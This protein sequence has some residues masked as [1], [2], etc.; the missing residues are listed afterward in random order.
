[1]NRTYRLATLPMLFLLAHCT[2]YASDSVQDAPLL[3]PTP[4]RDLGE[5]IQAP[6]PYA[7]R[8]AGECLRVKGSVLGGTTTVTDGT[9]DALDAAENCVESGHP[10]GTKGLVLTDR[11]NPLLYARQT[12]TRTTLPSGGKVGLEYFRDDSGYRV[13][14]GDL[15][16]RLSGGQGSL[17]PMELSTTQSSIAGTLFPWTAAAGTWA[18]PGDLVTTSPGMRLGRTPLDAQMFAQGAGGAWDFSAFPAQVALDPGVLLVPIQAVLFYGAGQEAYAGTFAQDQLALWDRIPTSVGP[19]G[20]R[21]QLGSPG[22]IDAT[23]QP[24]LRVKTRPGKDTGF[25]SQYLPDDVWAACGIQ[26]R[27]VNVIPMRVDA[28]FLSPSGHLDAQSAVI[29][30]HD[31]IREDPRFQPGP[32]TVLFAPRCADVDAGSGGGFEGIAGQSRNERKFSCVSN[33][34]GGN[35]LAH[36]LGH[37]IMNDT[38]HSTLPGN[39]MNAASGAGT[40]LD[41]YRQCAAARAHVE[42]LKIAMP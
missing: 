7:S 22:S 38:G 6:R 2:E 8:P 17:D 25:Y 31:H 16:F 1:M 18:A 39:V 4:P 30:A 32:I 40:S 3:A 15:Q 42:A 27:L 33:K 41:V 36:E 10:S 20:G 11:D 34:G 24:L 12:L 23:L 19:N 13:G 5:R 37:V 14:H 35:T 28:T 26:F 21:A 29:A 9:P